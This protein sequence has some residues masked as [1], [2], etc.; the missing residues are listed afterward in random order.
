MNIVSLPYWNLL[1]FPF[2][3]S[4]NFLLNLFLCVYFLKLL[5]W[6]WNFHFLFFAAIIYKWVLNPAAL[7][8]SVNSFGSFFLQI[9]QGLLHAQSCLQ[10]ETVIFLYNPYASSFLSFIVLDRTS[11]TTLNRIGESRHSCFV[12]C[13][14]YKALNL[15]LLSY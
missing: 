13:V 7:R 14:R 10:K 15:S 2:I 3:K 11:S 8:N 6:T 12:Y 5:W 1:Q 9:P 4:Y